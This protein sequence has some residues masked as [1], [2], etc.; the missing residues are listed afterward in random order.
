M[1]KKVLYRS[2]SCLVTINASQCS[3]QIF[4]K[5][6]NFSKIQLLTPEM[7]S[8]PKTKLKML[9][10]FI[11]FGTKIKSFLP[12]C[13]YIMVSIKLSNKRFGP[14][15]IWCLLVTVGYFGIN[16][17]KNCYKMKKKIFSTRDLYLFERTRRRKIAK[18]FSD[19][20]GVSL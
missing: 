16:G 15:K 20:A 4:F 10:N 5:F 13:Y 19:G 7:D 1:K 12:L 14:K 18:Q 9:N 6:S 2:E 8:R 3:G 11:F 17:Q